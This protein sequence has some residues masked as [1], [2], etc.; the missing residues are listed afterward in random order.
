MRAIAA[1][2]VR[3]TPFRAQRCLNFLE[4]LTTCPRGPVPLP[5]SPTD[6]R[7]RSRSELRCWPT[8][9]DLATEMISSDVCTS[10]LLEESRR[11]ARSELRGP[12]SGHSSD[13]D[14]NGMVMANGE[15][16]GCSE[17]SEAS[18][19]SLP[20]G[21]GICRS[22]VD[23]VDSG[24]AVSVTEVTTREQRMQRYKEARRRENEVRRRQVL[25]E[26]ARRRKAD[27]K[28]AAEENNNDIGPKSTSKVRGR[29]FGN[30]NDGISPIRVT[31][32]SPVHRLM[33][34]TRIEDATVE[35]LPPVKP[36][37]DVSSSVRF[38]DTRTQDDNKNNNIHE[39]NNHHNNN[40]TDGT[41]KPGILRTEGSERRSRPRERRNVRE[42]APMLSLPTVI[43]NNNVNI[44]TLKERR[45]RLGATPIRF[46]EIV[47]D[48]PKSGMMT[49][50]LSVLRDPPCEEDVARLL[51]RCQ[52]V[53]HYVP[54]REKL[55][56]FESLSRMGG[57]LARSTEDLG[58]SSSNPSPRG[59][60]RARSLHDLNRGGSKSMPVREMCRF[61]ETGKPETAVSASMKKDLT[62]T[63]Y[64]DFGI[65]N[66]GKGQP[67]KDPPKNP[68]A[69]C[70][71]T[72]TR[73]KNYAK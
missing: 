36:L 13:E 52:R 15:D 49:T 20:Y 8:S 57:R 33:S 23:S 3:Q 4:I 2:I 11:R 35:R 28:T 67:W 68:N 30:D 62:R 58:R 54:V 16:R 51:E 38:E 12:W 22:S 24:I 70:I 32:E 31:R 66:Y 45:E 21:G 18:D 59:K 43:T 39:R 63:R 34:A 10:N 72:S 6:Q 29:L 61:F 40:L 5:D 27:K 47:V 56:L 50:S 41:T 1:E 42:R 19:D 37:N 64:S 44:E 9:T 55:T 65:I 69:P 48:S 7:R 14:G 60:Q 53:D 17:S 73:R 25:E 71:R 46:P 26:D